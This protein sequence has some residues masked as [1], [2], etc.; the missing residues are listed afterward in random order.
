MQGNARR[1]PE[2]VFDSWQAGF[3]AEISLPSAVQVPSAEQPSLAPAKPP[4]PSSPELPNTHAPPS[5]HQPHT[6]TAHTQTQVPTSQQPPD[7]AGED[8]ATSMHQLMSRSIVP[9]YWQL[10]E[11][12]EAAAK[13]REKMAEV[14]AELDAKAKELQEIFARCCPACQSHY[15]EFAADNCVHAG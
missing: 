10:Q 12:A 11:E 6:A 7:E 3:A 8:V 1:Q 4:A 15:V 14:K 2:D 13:K 9:A 5:P